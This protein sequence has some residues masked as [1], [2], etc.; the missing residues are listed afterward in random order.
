MGVGL[1]GA[2]GGEEE[3]W[4]QCKMK[5]NKYIFKKIGICMALPKTEESPP[6]LTAP[7]SGFL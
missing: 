1:G 4:M 3:L 2:G 6:A 7:S 5:L